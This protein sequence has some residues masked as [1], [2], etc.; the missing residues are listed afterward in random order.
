M[1][2]FKNPTHKPVYYCRSCV[3]K[4]Q[5]VYDHWNTNDRTSAETCFETAKTGV[6]RPPEYEPNFAKNRLKSHVCTIKTRKLTRTTWEPTGIRPTL[7]DQKKKNVICKCNH[8]PLVLSKLLKRPFRRHQVN[9]VD[10]SRDRILCS[11]PILEFVSQCD[12]AESQT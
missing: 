7:A 9:Y 8:K 12:F 6:S 5:F 11:T 2:F 3:G 4:V 1:C 10:L